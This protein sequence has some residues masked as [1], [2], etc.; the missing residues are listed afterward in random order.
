MSPEQARFEYPDNAGYPDGMGYLD[1]GT[2][3]SVAGDAAAVF[4]IPSTDAE[5]DIEVRAEA[6]AYRA[7]SGGQEVAV[8]HIVRDGGMVTI[9][10]TVVDPEARDRGIG[11]SL[12]EHVLDEIRGNGERIRIQCA[13]VARFVALHP[14]YADLVA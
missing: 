3:R 7:V 5:T 2:A 6:T 13:E 1:E 12:I 9:R 14:E 10:S 11:T 8:M 4:A